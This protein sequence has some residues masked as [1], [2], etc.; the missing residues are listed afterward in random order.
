MLKSINNSLYI[1]AF[2]LAKYGINIKSIHNSCSRNRKRFGQGPWKNLKENGLLLIDFNSIPGATAA[3]YNLPTMERLLFAH[4]ESQKQLAIL[5]AQQSQNSIPSLIIDSQTIRQQFM[6][7]LKLVDSNLTTKLVADYTRV[8]A[9]LIW[10]SQI[11]GLK[12]ASEFGNFTSMP[13]FY[14]H[15]L[16]LINKEEL[17]NFKVKNLRTFQRK[18]KPFRNWAELNPT[19]QSEALNS[20]ISKKIGSKNAIK[21]SGWH[22]EQLIKLARDGKQ[23]NMVQLWTDLNAEAREKKQLT[24]SLSTVQALLMN[25][26]FKTRIER[27]RIGKVASTVKNSFVITRDRASVPDALWYIDGTPEELWYWSNE[28]KRL[29]RT[30]VIKVIDTHSD[31][32]VGYSIGETENTDLVYRAIKNAVEFRGTCAHQLVS[33][34]GSALQ[35]HVMKAWFKILFP[36]YTPGKA[37][38]PRSKRIEAIQGHFRVQILA[39]NANHSFGNITSKGAQANKD[40][41]KAHYKEFPQ[42]KGELIAQIESM[43]EAWNYRANGK[44]NVPIKLYEKEYEGRVHIGDLLMTELFYLWR[45]KPVKYSNE[46]LIFRQNNQ[47]LEYIA[48]CPVNM[49][50][51][52]EDLNKVAVFMNENIGRKFQIKFDPDNM[53]RVA[54]YFNDQFHSYAYTKLHTKEALWDTTTEDGKLLKQYQLVQHLQDKDIDAFYK[55]NDEYVDAHGL[56]K[57][58]MSIAQVNKT[59]RNKAGAKLKEIEIEG[60]K[61]QLEVTKKVPKIK[62]W[63]T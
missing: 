16:A 38:H 60:K 8:A 27:D 59:T 47:R 45:P 1:D 51:P 30:E 17:H 28:A 6:D 42:S 24:L 19:Q 56:A 52:K 48:P 26:A 14:N 9:W 32:I 43:I 11:N 58:T 37:G 21:M 31:C 13:L 10:V 18:F 4:N 55:R 44:G 25:E 54:L 62:R 50:T 33:D 39:R 3:K 29:K 57:Q 53:E 23:L 46:G 49:D 34:K 20:L 35:S 22:Q 12:M 5:A 7:K 61:I 40:Y 63:A 36:H 2:G 15:I 41:I